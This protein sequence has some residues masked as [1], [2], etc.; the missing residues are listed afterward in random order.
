MAESAG[1]L[2][3]VV[4]APVN[5][6]GGQAHAARAIVEGFARHPLVDARLV[7]ID[8]ALPGPWRFLT[9]WPVVRSVVRPLLFTATLLRE[10]RRADLVHVFCAAHTAFLFGA[11]PPIV[12]AAFL[13]RPIVLNYHD[14]RAESHI[15]RWGPLVRWAVRRAAAVVVPSGY[16]RDVFARAGMT[17]RV[18]PNVVDT[19][20]FRFRPPDPVT[21]RLVSARLLEPLYAVDNTIRAF[22]RVR[23]AVPEAT[24]EIYGDGVAAP[25]LRRLASDLGVPGVTFHGFRPHADMPGLFD[26]G[27]VLVNSSRIDNVP[28]V[29]IEAYASG[30]PIV[31]TPAGGIMYMV[32]PEVTA[33]VVP[34]DDPE[35]MADAVLRVLREP[36]LAGRLASAGRQRCGEYTWET[37]AEGWVSVYREATTGSSVNRTAPG[38][39]T[40][41]RSGMPVETR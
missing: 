30:M 13:R 2:R 37:A 24:L 8:P 14:G 32:E 6:V 18:V 20:A 19:S 11:L 9:S 16:L 36:G 28:H 17:G 1:S 34:F 26:A 5:A 4:T 21:P 23:A 10:V 25:A 39:T 22:A 33:L 35:A 12:V 15:R 40:A 7:A 38:Q 29:I 41:P 27:G 3:V 31:T